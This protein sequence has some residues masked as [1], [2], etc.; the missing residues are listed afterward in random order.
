MSHIYKLMPAALWQDFQQTGQFL[1]S[2]DD[3]RDGYIHLSTAAQVRGT[4]EK[5]F[6]EQENVYLLTISVSAT[7]TA[8]RYE[9]SRANQLFPHLYR[10]LMLS[11]VQHAVLV[12]QNVLAALDASA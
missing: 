1:G 8:L 10:A 7:D 12:D 11:E 3:V 5:Y 2:P 6:A 4:F 9:P